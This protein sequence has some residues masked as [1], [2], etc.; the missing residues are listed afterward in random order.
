MTYASGFSTLTDPA[1][2]SGKMD[3]T[4][5][6]EF[7]NRYKPVIRIINGQEM[8]SID[9]WHVPHDRKAQEELASLIRQ[10]KPAIIAFIKKQQETAAQAKRDR[11]ARIDSI[12]GLKEIREASAQYARYQEELRRVVNGDGTATPPKEPFDISHLTELREQHPL[13]DT[14]LKAKEMESKSNYELSAIG[15]EVMDAIADGADN[16][17]AVA[18]MNKLSDDYNARHQWD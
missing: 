16:D 10:N 3:D 14:Y 1:S 7:L 11:R 8:L 15:R 9:K 4:A 2:T 12:P 5:I 17:E 18:L 13:A 6:A